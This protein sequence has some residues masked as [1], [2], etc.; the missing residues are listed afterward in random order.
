MHWPFA[1]RGA[2]A[3]TVA[4]SNGVPALD[5]ASFTTN[6]AYVT[7]WLPQRLLDALDVVSAETDTSRPDVIR[8]LLF[9]HLHGRAELVRLHVWARNRPPEPEP[10]IKFAEKRPPIDR[11]ANV[12]M[13]GKS[14]VDMKLWMPT[15]L[16]VSLVS[17]SKAQGLGLSDGIRKILVLELLGAQFHERWQAA[18]GLV[19]AHYREMER[20]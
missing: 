10:E 2:R 9:E 18:V 7:V 16:K 11:R 15:P 20:S 3:S 13:L 12:Q 4:G 17:H 6:D 14:A 1:S 8:A 19:P 5:Y